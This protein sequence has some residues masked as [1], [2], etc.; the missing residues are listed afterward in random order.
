MTERAPVLSEVLHADDVSW[1]TPAAEDRPKAANAGL[2]SS[3]FPRE[4]SK[5]PKTANFTTQPG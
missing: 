4:S 3:R 1:F 2:E 5:I